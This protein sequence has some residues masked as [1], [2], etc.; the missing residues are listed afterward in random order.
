MR[1]SKIS[2]T[3]VFKADAFSG[4]FKKGQEIK[5]SGY[6]NSYGE[7]ITGY[8]KTEPID[9]GNSLDLYVKGHREVA[10]SKELVLI[11]TTEN[12]SKFPITLCSYFSSIHENEGAG[13]LDDTNG[14]PSKEGKYFFIYGEFIAETYIQI[15]EIPMLTSGNEL[16]AEYAKAKRKRD[17]MLSKF[18]SAKN[19]GS[20]NFGFLIDYIKPNWRGADWRVIHT[21]PNK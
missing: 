14:I 4:V 9:D 21:Y 20:L 15:E 10:F 19:R 3:I 1:L 18:N 8:M 17:K 13:Y 11:Q 2:Q 6:I 16:N 7:I 5:L 12:N